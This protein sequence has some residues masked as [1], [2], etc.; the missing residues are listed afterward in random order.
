MRSHVAWAVADTAH[1]IGFG[2]NDLIAKSLQ[3][4]DGSDVFLD[5][6]RRGRITLATVVVGRGVYRPGWRWSAHVRPMVGH[7]SEAHVGYIISG[8]MVVRA[9]D[10]AQ[11]E[12]GPGD[13]FEAPPGHDAW[14]VGDEPCVAL[15][16][17][18]RSKPSRS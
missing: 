9:P 13:A 17:A 18:A 7:A 8:R 12:L 10:G 5:D 2:M 11:V 16:F 15:D 6:S 3:T 14:V 1:R 4:P